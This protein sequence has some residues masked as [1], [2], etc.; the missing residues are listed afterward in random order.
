MSHESALN[1]QGI[2]LPGGTFNGDNFTWSQLPRQIA[3]NEKR[4]LLIFDGRY[5]DSYNYDPRQTPDHSSGTPRT[6]E[7]RKQALLHSL[8]FDEM[9]Q[10]LHKISVSE[11]RPC[12]WLLR[13]EAYQAWDPMPATHSASDYAPP[14]PP[15]SDTRPLL[16]IRGKQGTGK[17]TLMKFACEHAEK[18]RSGESI[19]THFFHTRGVELQRSVEGMYRSLLVSLVSD[20]TTAEIAE[21]LRRSG[22][23][24]ADDGW[25][26]MELENLVTL[27][28]D[29]LELR[30]MTWFVD[31]LNECNRDQIHKMAMFFNDLTERA[32]A[33][34][35]QLRICLAS[36]HH[37]Y[38]SLR[39]ATGLVVEN[40]PGHI[41]NVSAF[42]T[43]KLH[44]GRSLLAER[45]RDE[46]RHR[47]QGVFIWV[48]LVA[49]ILQLDYGRARLRGLMDR[50][51][52]I[53]RDLAELYREIFKDMQSDPD[54][55]R[56]YLELPRKCT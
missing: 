19:L 25:T 28:I 26:I 52:S 41:E 15:L 24:P 4:R 35:L 39:H 13:C 3:C 14:S 38:I 2:Q 36:R 33:R 6:P 16:W 17:S 49:Y 23:D 40:E 9:S 7:E 47:V 18:S 1:G 32:L 46:M 27:A 54:L 31:A 12:R 8:R 53:P 45:I 11:A 21:L 20:A 48:W 42:I 30:P 34:D 51:R 50:L 55:I 44:I 10:R 56:V 37:P 43:N 29:I 22:T 5:E